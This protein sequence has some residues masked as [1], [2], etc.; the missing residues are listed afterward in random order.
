MYKLI[1]M[2]KII[3][4]K[5]FAW[6]TSCFPLRRFSRGGYFSS[7]PEN[8]NPGSVL[9]EGTALYPAQK[10]N[11]A[12]IHSACIKLLHWPAGIGQRKIDWIFEWKL[13]PLDE[14]GGDT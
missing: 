10:S 6:K 13:L 3:Y 8:Q 5:A 1:V 9:G 11:V 4:I 12:S 14:F 2:D 7:H